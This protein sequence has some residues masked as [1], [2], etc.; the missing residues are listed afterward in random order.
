MKKIIFLIIALSLLQFQVVGAAEITCTIIPDKLEIKADGKETVNFK[1]TVIGSEGTVK[2]G[3]KYKIIEAGKKVEGGFKTTIPGIYYFKA[4]SENVDSR[5]VA[6]TATAKEKKLLKKYMLKDG[7]SKIRIETIYDYDNYGNAIKTIN[8]TAEGAVIERFTEYLYD[9]KGNI[10]KSYFKDKDG[11][12]TGSN[13]YEYDKNLNL[14]KFVQKNKDGATTS[15][16]EWV[17]TYDKNGKK[18]TEQKVI[19]DRNGNITNVKETMLDARGI[20]ILEKQ[21]FRD[22][23]GSTILETETRYDTY[24]NKV[25]EENKNKDGVIAKVIEYEY[26]KDGNMFK[27]TTKDSS[28][29]VTNIKEYETEKGKEGLKIKQIMKAIDEKGMIISFSEN[30]YDRYGNIVKYVLKDQEGNI[31]EYGEVKYDKQGNVVQ[32]ATYDKENKLLSMA[33][34]MY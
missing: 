33:E 3:A 20:K 15:E 31:S 9:K 29:T 19:K 34:S 12:M 26:G 4:V 28:G 14:V 13:E 32:E 25:R 18:Q 6:V 23:K 24:G 16:N 5:S 17:Y 2:K 1:V 8:K 21:I 7:E 22:R 27:E 10:L 30:Y 11:N